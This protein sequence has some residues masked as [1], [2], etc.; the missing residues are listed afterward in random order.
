VLSITNTT[1]TH[2]PA[3]TISAR[4]V[5]FFK[6]HGRIS[7][8]VFPS[9]FPKLSRPPPPMKHSQQS[10]RDRNNLLEAVNS[11]VQARLEQSLHKAIQIHILKEEN[12]QQTQRLWDV[13]VK[14][15]K[16]PTV[17]LSPKVSMSQVFKQT[18]GKLLILGSE[19]SGKTTTLLELSQDLIEIAQANFEQPVPVIFNLSSWKNNQQSISDW[20]ISEIKLKYN[21]PIKTSKLLIDNQQILPLLDGLDELELAQQE[22]CIRAINQWLSLANRPTNII[23]CTRLEDYKKCKTKLKLYG[24][25][26]LH[27]LTEPQIQEYLV[28]S[29]SRELWGILKDEPQ[30]LELAKSPLLLNMMIL[31][32]EELLIQAW[33]RIKSDKE[34]REYL[35]NA[36]VRRMLTWKLK[37]RCYRDGKEPRPEKARPWLVYLAKRINSTQQTEVSLDKLDQSW[38]QTPGQKSLYRLGMLLTIGGILGMKRLILRFIL[39]RSKSIPWNYY[40][41]LNYA[42]ERFLL[43]KVGRKYRFIHEILPEHIAQM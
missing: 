41:F 7:S 16:R 31:A 33:K 40:R 2:L 28:A 29:R 14:I 4:P 26:F 11:E 22:L 27:P 9:P 3:G 18:G 36:Y 6:T 12:P 37:S 19:G 23:V 24:A 13:D 25:M 21:I 39:W 32:Y 30:F 43:Q 38:L 42:T 20:L 34:R 35:L 15:G 10:V 17:R 1:V 5:T 8:S